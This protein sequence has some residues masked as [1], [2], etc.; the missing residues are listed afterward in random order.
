MN[1]TRNS[2][3]ALASRSVTAQSDSL[4]DARRTAPAVEHG[5]LEL[6]TCRGMA[7]S[8]ISGERMPEVRISAVLKRTLTTPILGGDAALNREECRVRFRTSSCGLPE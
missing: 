4:S 5:E 3:S 1:W 7:T 2:R 8:P 6:N